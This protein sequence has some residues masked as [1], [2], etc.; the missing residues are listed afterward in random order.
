MSQNYAKERVTITLSS[1]LI[2]WLD[3]VAVADKKIPTDFYVVMRAKNKSMVIEKALRHYRK[4]LNANR[5]R[6]KKAQQ[7]K[8]AEKLDNQSDA[9]RS[10]SL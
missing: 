8:I 3:S 4:H 7:K 2:R 9:F 1:E 10:K 5:L 6:Q